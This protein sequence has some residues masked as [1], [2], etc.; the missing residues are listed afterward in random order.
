MVVVVVVVAAIVVV[1]VVNRHY[2]YFLSSSLTSSTSPPSSSTTTTTTTIPT[3]LTQIPQNP[4]QP[5]HSSRFNPETTQIY[6]ELG[7]QGAGGKKITTGVK[8]LSQAVR[9]ECIW[10]EGLKLKPLVMQAR[11]PIYA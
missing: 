5:R 3:T 4:G 6:E 9:S 1:I 10:G 2:H 7:M 11:Q 8:Y